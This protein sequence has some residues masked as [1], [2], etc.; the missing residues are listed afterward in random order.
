MIDVDE[1]LSR[2]TVEEKCAQLAGVWFAELAT[3]NQLDATKMGDALTHGIGQISR[4][5]AQTGLGPEDTATLTNGIQRHLVE[6]TRLGIPAVVHEESTGGFCAREAT[7]FPHGTGLSAT[8]DPD[9]A[10]EVAEVIGR[11]LRAVGAR[12]T[13]APV[14]DIARDPRWGRVEETY[15]EDP[16]LASRFGV[17]YVRGV[18]SQ[19]V[20]CTLKHYVGYGASEGGLNWGWVSAGPRHLRDVL[21]APFRAAI[22]EAGVGA[23]MPSYNDIDGL[24]VHGSPELLTGLLRDELGFTGVT[25]A[26]YFGVTCLETFHHVAEDKADAARQALLAGL[27]VELPSYEC[28]RT[29][30][31]QV[32]AGTV[33]IEA[34]DAACRR[35][36]TQKIEL[37]LFDDPYVDAGAASATFDTPQDRAL[38]R[39]AVSESVVVLTNDGTLP[40]TA[41]RRIAVLGPSADDPRLLMG[42][43]H[44]PAHLE[45]AAAHLAPQGERMEDVLPQNPTPTPLEALREQVEVVDDLADADVAVV[46]VGGRS[47]LRQ[48]DTSGEM[49]D[50]TDLRLPAD[51]LAL[52]EEVA[53]TGT[54]VV[55][56]VVG[57]RVH[58]L[59]E[60]VP[61]AAALVL[62]WL[63]G[64]E[65][66]TGLADVL[67]GA[68]EASGRLPVSILRSSGQV[69]ASV[70]AHHG[71]GTSMIWGDYVD[72][73]VA[74][75][76]PFGHGLSYTMWERSDLAV[77]AGSTDDD[78]TLSVTTSNTGDRRGTDVVQVFVT[79]EVASVS[80]PKF[81]LLAFCRV[82]A[83]PGEST[84]VTFRVPAGRLGFTDADLRFRVEPGAFTF[85]VGDQAET[86]TLTG[87]VVFPDRNALLPPTMA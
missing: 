86:V 8:W 24:P 23:V 67:T 27:D 65:G 34:I 57:G 32:E 50:T 28:Y 63:P 48:E 69:G 54:P 3:D 38:A 4:I 74:P 44:F 79:D 26:D 62:L 81:R 10:R 31:G 1:L 25:V 22:A 6:E 58:E 66:G 42:D 68:V 70:G 82:D 2:M 56:V 72:G 61:H 64:Q 16:E 9:L 75:L 76:F 53:A 45:L 55:V 18:Q 7:Q 29:L 11:Q 47:G 83:D 37:G 39:R 33:P 71:G 84:T 30:P 19:G 80:Q 52:I 41:G 20:A 5:A 87:D 15:G 21:A 49:R 51:Q 36:L 85:R 46:C 77:E 17:A 43:Y 73:P 59:S 13:L 60:V 12:L 35:V 40:L 14:V 78:L